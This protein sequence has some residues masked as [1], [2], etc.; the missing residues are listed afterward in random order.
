MDAVPR[1]LWYCVI[2]LL[3]FSIPSIVVTGNYTT[4]NAPVP[5]IAVIPAEHEPIAEGFL[6]IVLDGVPK[7]M[8]LDP[9]IMPNLAEKAEVGTT[10][11]VRSGPLTMTGPCVREMGS[12]IPS[13]PAQGL[14]NFHPVHPGNLDGWKLASEQM[15]VGIVGDYVWMD[16]YKEQESINQSKHYY[17]HADFYLGDEEGFATLDKWLLEDEHQAIVGHFAGVDHVGHRYGTSSTEYV[18][19][20]QW[21]DEELFKVLA[22]VPDDWVVMIT[23]DHGL[24]EAGAHGSPDEYVRQVAAVIWGQGIEQGNTIERMIKQRDIASLPNVIFALPFPPAMDSRI[25]LEAFDLSEEHRQTI[26]SWNWNAMVQRQEWLIE[27]GYPGVEGLSADVIE[28]EKIPDE[29]MGIRTIDVILTIA[30]VLLFTVTVFILAL[31]EFN[32]RKIAFSSAGIVLFSYSFSL[33]VPT[34]VLTESLAFERGLIGMITM[35]MFYYLWKKGSSQERIESKFPEWAIMGLVV[36][37][38]I[39]P[40]ARFSLG[41]VL[42]WIWISREL[43][44]DKSKENLK[45]LLPAWIVLSVLVLLSHSRII[46]THMVR[47]MMWATQHDFIAHTLLSLVLTFAGLLFYAVMLFEQKSTTW[48]IALPS[49]FAILPL[50]MYLQSNFV[51][52]IVLGI[53]SV[54][55][56]YGII[57]SKTNK[58]GRIVELSLLAWLTISW[59]GWCAAT[60]AII[61]ATTEKLLSG[62]LSNLFEQRSNIVD[63]RWRLALLSFLPLIIWFVYWWAMGQVEGFSYAILHTREIDPGDLNLKGGYI[64]D[65][66]SPSNTWVAFMGA[67]PVFA[68]SIILLRNIGKLGAPLHLFALILLA[69]IA[70]LALHLS[71]SATDARLM[72]KSTF[73]AGLAIILLTIVGLI[74]LYDKLQQKIKST[75]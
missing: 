25:P 13:R 18:E 53:L 3:V 6:Q 43:W 74:I 30:A 75:S 67:G 34:N 26:D 15:S 2:A 73:D 22:N 23:A 39:S 10:M 1:R 8:M 71:I 37:F 60:A 50:T 42:I 68:I 58:E 59:G 4:A 7:D 12:G 24:T 38:I 49:A 54:S 40:W 72:F 16:L 69:R 66:T 19:K 55:F 17:G 31:K 52:W 41:T 56:V 14:N 48:K 36:L 63:E 51:D 65:R 35:L 28:W 47:A 20:M 32:N 9:E 62:R 44:K 61:L 45:L 46:G 64:G 57:T 11:T 33:I 29:D 21:V 27:N 70:S 5:D